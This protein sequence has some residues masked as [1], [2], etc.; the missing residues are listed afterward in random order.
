MM[1]PIA[2]DWAQVSVLAL[3][4]GDVL[5]FTTPR[6]LSDAQRSVIQMQVAREFPGHKVVLLEDGCSLQVVRKD[7]V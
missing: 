7:D 3:H 5:V 4:P 6:T 1:D 2:L